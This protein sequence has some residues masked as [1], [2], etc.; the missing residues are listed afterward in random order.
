MQAQTNIKAVWFKVVDEVKQRVIH[1][2]LW[3]ALEAG[4]AVTV[5]EGQFVVGFPMGTFHLAGNLNSLDH[6]NIIEATISKYMGERL[7]LRII[8]GGSMED[9]EAVKTKE[10]HA[11][12][13][14]EAAAAR[15]HDATS[16]V[17]IWETLL[18]KVGRK[19]STMPLRQLPQSRAVYIEEAL[20][21]ISDTMDQVIP[22]GQPPDDL[23]QRA[24]ARVLEKVAS[25]VEVPSTILALDLLR[26][27]RA[28]Q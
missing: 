3:K 12:A 1:P 8:E 6:K 22:E 14:R 11:R 17:K 23:T 25:L 15:R 21:M 28:S 20:Q 13:M 27:R 5:E 4:V 9:W 18:E 7:S 24:I 26:L 19:Y 10:E 2:T 16:S